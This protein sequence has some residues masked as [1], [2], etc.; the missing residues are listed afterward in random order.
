MLQRLR[1]NAI[2]TETERLLAEIKNIDRIRSDLQKLEDRIEYLER[3]WRGQAPTLEI[4]R[5][6]TE[7]IPRDAWI[8][9]FSYDEKGVKLYGYA[10]SASE[11]I[12]ILEKSPLF[13]DVVFLSTITKGRDGKE[14]FRIGF[15]LTA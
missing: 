6:V 8:Q 2:N 7:R 1:L 14:R 11:L 9:D 5:E 12:P 3:L 10:D 13:R 15:K 4:L